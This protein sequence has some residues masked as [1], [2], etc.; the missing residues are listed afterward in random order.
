LREI[1]ERLQKAQ[2][3]SKAT[4]KSKALNYLKYI[5]SLPW[6]EIRE[7][8]EPKAHENHSTTLNLKLPT[9]TNVS[10]LSRGER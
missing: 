9:I 10:S 2:S 6:R 4:S 1:R 3:N 5:V 8:G 7:R